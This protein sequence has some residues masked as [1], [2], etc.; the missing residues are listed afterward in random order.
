MTFKRLR[1]TAAFLGA[2]GLPAALPAQEREQ[3]TLADQRQQPAAIEAEV[4]TPHAECFYFTKEGERFKP[5]ISNPRDPRYRAQFGLS[6]MTEDVAARLGGSGYRSTSTDATAEPPIATSKNPIDQYIYKGLQ[7]AGV[8]PADRTN[9][10]EFMRRVSIDLTGRPPVMERVKS[11]IADGSPTKRAKYIDELMASPLF[12]D[13]W[14]MYWGDRFKNAQ[15]LP[16]SGI[17][18]YPEGRD[19]FY[20]WIKNNL[21]TNKPYDQVARELIASQG[22]NS[23]ETEQGPINWIVGGRS[24]GPVQDTFDQQ[25]V[26]VATTFLGLSHTNCL[27]CHNGRGHLTQL[28][29]WGGQ[30][31]RY[32]AWQLAA[33]VAKSAQTRTVPDPMNAP[34][35]YYWA[36]TDNPK[37]SDYALNTTTGNRPSRLPAS[38]TE[39]TI[40][41]VYFLNGNK[42]APGENYRVA[43]A[44]EVTADPLFAPPP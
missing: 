19:A 5:A 10:Y 36:V 9:E 7:D 38:P 11:Y 2:V 16:S 18:R 30:T 3:V 6:R 25:T 21:V 1:I 39:K 23:W 41:P 24:S 34:N 40:A 17:N 4:L 27:L 42:P 44:R 32:Q 33:F 28:S 20:N 37:T 14:T 15:N 8:T 22:T 13:R 31:T 26:Q 35:K 43:L 12:I 29:V